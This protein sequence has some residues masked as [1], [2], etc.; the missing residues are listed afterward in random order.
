MS[1][2]I[3]GKRRYRIGIDF[4]R[5]LN[6]NLNLIWPVASAIFKGAKCCRT[7]VKVFDQRTLFNILSRVVSRRK[8]EK[9]KEKIETTYVSSCARDSSLSTSFPLSLP[10][11][12]QL[13][14][15]LERL[16]NRASARARRIAML[17]TLSEN[18]PVVRVCKGECVT[19]SYDTSLE[20]NIFFSS[21]DPLSSYAKVFFGL[22]DSDE[23]RHFR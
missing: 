10:P 19:R 6:L 8:R 9:K 23:N 13:L 4:R 17:D 22:V 16:E 14:P 2:R 5:R 21:S 7:I 15:A 1:I 20:F 11:F 3:A 18:V 12:L